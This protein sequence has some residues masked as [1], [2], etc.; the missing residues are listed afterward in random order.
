MALRVTRPGFI[1]GIRALKAS[2]GVA[3]LRRQHDGDAPGDAQLRLRPVPRRV[4]LQ[5]PEKRLTYPWAKGLKVD[6]I[7]EYYREVGLHDWTHAETGAPALKA[8]HPEFEMWNQGHST[9][10][11]GVAC[12]DCHMPYMRDGRTEDQ[13]PSRAEPRCSTSPRVPDVPQVVRGGAAGAVPRRS[14]AARWNLRG[15]GRWTR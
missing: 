10:A 2:Q 7:Y 12:A 6:Q 11:P 15:T 8:Q 5:G 14:T 4:L 3:G 1:E 13:R 9:R